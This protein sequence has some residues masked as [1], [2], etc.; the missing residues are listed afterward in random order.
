MRQEK[1]DLNLNLYVFKMIS[2]IRKKYDDYCIIRMRASVLEVIAALFAIIYICINIQV[3]FKNVF[4]YDMRQSILCHA[5]INQL[6]NRDI[7]GCNT[8]TIFDYYDTCLL[9]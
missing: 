7:N 2:E 4:Q 9:F 3:R 6:G 8:M 5:N 1:N